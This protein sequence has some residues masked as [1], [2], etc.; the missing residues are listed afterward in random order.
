MRRI[1]RLMFIAGLVL[2][3]G[4]FASPAHANLFDRMKEIYQAPDRLQELQ[5]QYHETIES[6]ESQLKAQQEYLR[7]QAE[8][9]EASR[10]QTEELLARQEQMERENKL[11]RQ[12]NEALLAENQELIKRIEQAKESRRT[13]IRG[14]AAAAGSLALLFV[15]YAAAVRIWRYLVWR[16]QGKDQRGALLP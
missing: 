11:F 16:K 12:Q 9:L 10:K 3:C 8:H 7:I 5:N 1:R 6:L 13:M 14:A 2:A 15:L 4:A